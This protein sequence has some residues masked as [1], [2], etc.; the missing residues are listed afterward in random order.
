M[1][2][3]YEPIN[4]DGDLNDDCTTA[5]WHGLYGRAELMADFEAVSGDEVE[6]IR[7]KGESWWCAVFDSEGEV[8]SSNAVGG[9]IGSGARAREVVELV[10]RLHAARRPSPEG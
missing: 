6:V 1:N 2:S 7:W 3:L 5:R 10:M 9:N 4:W 8:W